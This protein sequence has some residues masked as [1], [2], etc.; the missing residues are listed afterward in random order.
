MRQLSTPAVGLLLALLCCATSALATS[1]A[2]RD[3]QAL[4][5]QG[6]LDQALQQLDR[7][8]KAAPQ[9]AE[10]RF[11]RGL[12]LVRL[13][14]NDEAVKAFF[15]M[16]RDF[17][18]LPEPFNNLAV[19]YAQQGDYEKARD[20]LESA[21]ATHPSYTVAHENLGDIY[22]ALAAAAYNRALTLDQHNPS[23]RA[24]LNLINQL[25]SMGDGRTPV[26][27]AKAPP[28]ARVETA[29]A[30]APTPAPAPT[31]A[32]TPEPASGSAL[33]TADAAGLERTIQ[34]WAKDWSSRNADR[35]LSSYA[36]DFSP[37]GGMSRKAWE[38]QRRDR[39]TQPKSISVE[40]S[41]LKLEPVADGG[42]RATFRQDYTSDSFS[43][44]ATKV[45]E[46]SRTADGW[47]IVREF[48]R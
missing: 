9:D 18:Q 10:A 21:L 4:M 39:V 8:I 37:E 44:R 7:Q 6:K 35:Y 38:A 2:V 30:A 28:A 33:S 34:A 17:P 47:K 11:T 40:I 12:V 41:D 16:T 25:D 13:N 42:A 23:V 14:R 5:N 48:S 19:I 26:A 29:P 31:A 20:S 15:A 36:A 24:K 22:A 1:A 45:L 3:A 46:L 32:S 43:N 27:Q